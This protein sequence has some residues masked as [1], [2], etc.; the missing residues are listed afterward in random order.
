MRNGEKMPVSDRPFR[1]APTIVTAAD[2]VSGTTPEV[3]C[4]GGD[5]RS[6][7]SLA[8]VPIYLEGAG[9]AAER[10]ARRIPTTRFFYCFDFFILM[11][12]PPFQK[13]A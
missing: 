2:R 13:A 9:Q 6:S 5:C 3:G 11:N 1:R 8:C 10:V 4:R 7:E 12:T